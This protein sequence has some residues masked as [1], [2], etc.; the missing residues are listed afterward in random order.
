MAAPQDPASQVSAQ[1]SL[2][3]GL[4]EEEALVAQFVAALGREQRAL[5]DGLIDEL[6]LH[7]EEKTKL[8]ARLTQAA[9]QRNARLAALG[10]P[11]DRPGL[12]A[13]CAAHPEEKA[14]SKHWAGIL[15]LAAQ[16]NALNRLNGELINMRLQHNARA[17]EAL[18]GG[19]NAL[20]LYGPDGQSKLSGSPRIN[21]AV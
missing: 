12:D 14:V 3:R 17:L 5:T 8:A 4:A 1:A 19:R 16:A 6:P 10:L 20:D 7:A 2:A 15:A 21:D 9:E 13:W 11:A 18:Q